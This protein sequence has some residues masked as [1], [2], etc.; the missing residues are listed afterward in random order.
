MKKLIGLIAC[1]MLLGLSSVFAQSKEV[2]G[3]VVDKTDGSPLP[4]VS[5]AVKG[6]T[7]GTATDINGKYFIKVSPQDIL[8]F[9]FVGMENQEI[10]VGSKTVI[11]VKLGSSRVAVE[12]VVVTA[13]GISR[14]E[15][16]LGYSVA[17]VGGDEISKARETSVVSAL[18]GKVSGVRISQQSGSV[19]GSSKIIIRGANSLGGNNQPLFVVDGMPIDNGYVGNGIAGAVDYGNRAGDINPDDVETMSVLKGAA[20]TALY[21][22]RAKNGAIIIVTK[23]GKKGKLNININSSFRF[24]NPL[25]L[26]DY[27]NTYAQGNEGVYDV[28]DING[29]GPKISDVQDQKFTNFKGDEVTLQAYPNNVKDF[30]DTGH[31]F[32][33]SVDFGGG[34]ET[35]DFR[36]GFTNTTQ[37][38]IIPGS[39]MKKN[40]ITLNAG[41]K[42]NDW[43]KTRGSVSYVRSVRDGLSSQGSNDPNI[44]SSKI[45]GMSRTMDINNLKNNYVNPETGEQIFMD[46]PGKKVNNPYWIINNNKITSDLERIIGSA[47]IEIKPFEWLTIS[48]R[49]GIDFYNEKRRTL[50]TK[51]TAGE[52][53]GKFTTHN[54]S[55]RIINNDLMAALNLDLSDDLKFSAIMGHNINQREYSRVSVTATELVVAGLYTYSNAKTKE[56]TNY[57]EQKRLM[58]VY[59]DFGFEYKDTY[60]LNITGRNDWSS[61]LPINN[62][63]YFYPAVSFGFVFS[64]LIP[65][66]DIL[67]FGK[68]R[69]NWANVGSDEDPYQLDFQYSSSSTYYSQYGLSGN[70]PHGGIVAFSSPR[71]I[72]PTDLKPQ[73]QVSY[74]IGLDLRFLRGRIT[75]DATYYMY[76]T[77]DQIVSIDIPLSTGFFAKKINVGQVTNEGIELDLGLQ[78][79]KTDDFS[80]D[81][82]FTFNT[83]KQL[84]KKLADGLKDYS[85]TS[86]WSGLQIKAAPGES[87]G[88]YGTG[89]KRNDAGEFIINKNTGLREVVSNQ[90]LGQV[91]PDWTL[92][93][94]NSFS[95][96]GLSL[97][98]LVDIKQG[99][100]IYSGTT[101]ALRS[102]GLAAETVA[103]RGTTYVDNGVNAVGS[104]DNVTYEQN[105]TPVQ[106]IQKYWDNMSKTSNT[107]GCVFDAS[108]IKLRE[109]QLSYQIPKNWLKKL[110]IIQS[111]SIGI[112]GR[113]LWIIQDHVPH[114]DPELNFFGP[115][116]IG[117]GVEFNSVPSSRSFGFNVKLNF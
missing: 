36:L 96:K 2:T 25:K 48:N 102:S 85:L 68:L 33:N 15:K 82:N 101:S 29:W 31:T 37:T 6:T 98:F 83:N 111:A 23:K 57:S 95:Y 44:L 80:W 65:E 20:A 41:R 67:D 69:L 108:Y 93:I 74:E 47:S 26:P 117:G 1:V 55:N 113:N 114:V 66:N 115:G 97:S 12:E 92:G 21:G 39:E 24:D 10:T 7:Q 87:F 103:I 17:S 73:N 14:K 32:I 79:L 86:G 60:F 116:E 89:W 58:G 51:G 72:P 109:V 62:R 27:Q 90:R 43:I 112:E 56:P 30:F 19:G 13:V 70:F 100:V 94:N 9:S 99:G 84:V 18:A 76:D 34:D 22:A 52:I 54:L 81:M 71:V 3:T 50:Y 107:E 28:K 78:P 63:S 59:A 75:L 88:I 110:S 64:K 16:S 40:N 35:S 77:E 106:S 5:V 4:G 104:G 11:N 8:V 45:L 49:A 105:T 91:D 61:T 42:I 53:G 46:G 38:G